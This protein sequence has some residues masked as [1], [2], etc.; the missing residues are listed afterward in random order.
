[1]KQFVALTFAACLLPACILS[2]GGP[3][4][5]LIQFNRDI[6][7]IL[8]EN[9]YACHGPDKHS[10][11]AGLRLDTE[12]GA[13]GKVDDIYPIV[14]GKPDASEVVRRITTTDE[15]DHMPPLDSTKKLT[16]EQIALIKRWIEQGAKWEG[17]W[18]YIAPKASPI[19]KVKNKTWPRN[20]ID[21][22]ILAK[23]EAKNLKQSPEA[24]KRTLIRR[25]SFDLTGLPPSA[26]EVDAFLADKSPDA[27]EKVVDRLFASPHFGERMAMRWLDL[28]RY[29][30]TAGYH[31]DQN[32][33]IW[34]YRDYVIKSFNANKPF[35][36]FTIEQIAGDLL[37]DATLEQKIAS[38]YNRLHMMTGEGGAQDKEYRA[39]YAA[40]RVRTTSSVWLGSTMG[41]CEC[42]DHKFDPFSTKDFYS[43]EAFFSDLKEKGFY[44]GGLWEPFIQV[45]TK[46][47]AA[48]SKRLDASIAKLKKIIDTPTEGLAASQKIWE[49]KTQSDIENEK[50]IWVPQKPVNVTSR[51]GTKLKTQDDLSILTSGK[52]PPKEVYI[53]RL[54]TDLPRVTAIRLETLTHE[55]F[56]NKGLSRGNGNF[57]LSEFQVVAVANGKTNKVKIAKA[58]A[59]YEQVAQPISAAID[60]KAETGWAVDGHIKSQNHQ[61][62]F[63]FAEPVTSE[64]G[65]VFIVRLRHE[66]PHSQHNIGLFRLSLTSDSNPPLPD[67]VLPKNILA[68]LKSPAEERNAEQK[69]ELA[70]YYRGIAPELAETREQLLKVSKQKEDLTKQIPTTLVSVHEKPK[71]IRILRRGNWMDDG[72]EIV[73]AALPHFLPQPDFKGRTPTR[74]DLARW[75]VS[76]ENP[77]TARVFVNRWWKLFFGTG[78]SKILDD[79][80]SQGEWPT[81]PELLDYLALEFSSD[82]DVKRI[83]KLMVMSSAYRESSMANEKLREADP[84][85]R[86]VARQAR[87][88]LDAEMIR[89]NALA[90][91]GLLSPTMFGPSA[92]P[93]QTAGYYAQLNFPK[94][95][96]QEDHGDNEYRRGVYTH[97]QR[98]FLHPMLMA[99]DAPSREECTAERA[100]SN[101]PLQSLVLLNDP[102]FVEAARVFAEKIIQQGGGEERQKLQWAYERALS[103]SP[104]Q[105]ELKTLT[106]LLEKHRQK[107]QNDK[108]AAEEFLKVGDAP[109]NKTIDPVELAAWTSVSRTILNLHETI[110]RF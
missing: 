54:K 61:A 51:H 62:V 103:R 49:K 104:N 101:T 58:N 24:D 75:L 27:Y 96:Y 34:P 59:D 37:P 31:G 97:W 36:Q 93:Y 29:A 83:M 43:F 92:K 53:V 79:L 98:T 90:I 46:E 14:P 7:P 74:L 108:T 13:F 38:G 65:T 99:F 2:A 9:C 77:L 39:K 5:K 48:E 89:D 107:F 82:W 41:C 68:I 55:S 47:Q 105:N 10:R 73:T 56:P 72:G 87:F 45:P 1:M 100:H 63:T 109:V 64:P 78:L 26:Q 35:D 106:T 32:V 4:P 6:R 88:R 70:K 67:A 84:F 11:K 21:N 44:P 20:P 81:H 86:L 30:D 69:D 33:S 3:T 42:H 18:A 95:E 52:N 8:S 60:G 12:S 25:L 22:F 91:S 102:T 57:V 40:D 19:P 17:H 16:S 80:G 23:L 110:T 76:R 94:R 50:D 15:D 85:N 71:Q 66:S 28:V